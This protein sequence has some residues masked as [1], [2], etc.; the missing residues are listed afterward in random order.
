MPARPQTWKKACM[1]EHEKRDGMEPVPYNNLGKDYSF[2]VN[3]LNIL[4]PRH[5]L[6]NA[7]R[8]LSS[9]L[10]MFSYFNGSIKIVLKILIIVA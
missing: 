4:K 3:N 9:D 1:L 7:L 6:P 10:F 5:Y 8:T 2:A